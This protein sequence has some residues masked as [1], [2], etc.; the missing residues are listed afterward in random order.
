MS[1][2]LTME[3]QPRSSP[4]GAALL[5]R[6]ARRFVL[7]QLERLEHGR[8]EVI[9]GDQRRVFG[10]HDDSGLETTVMVHDA[11]F[12]SA[13]AFGG[14]IGAGE[15][16]VD[17]AW[18]SDDLTAVMRIMARNTQL[19]DDLDR[20]IAKI[21]TPL[22]KLLHRLR[23][24]TRA[25]SKRNIAAHYDIDDEFFKL[26]LD[27]T[28]TYSCAYFETPETDLRE[29]SIEKY[30]RI[31][32]KLQLQPGDELLEIGCG[33]GGFAIHAAA[34]YGCQVV[35]TTISE[36]QYQ[37]AY[38]RVREAGL[39]ELVD[40][41]KLDYRDLEASLGRRFDKIVSIEMIEAVGHRF[42]GD[43]FGVCSRMLR[44]HGRMA[45]QAITIADHRYDQYRR[46]VDFIQRYIFPGGLVPSIAAM[47]DAIARRTDL[48]MTHLED[49]GEHY[50]T[51]LE[52]WRERL[53][54]NA[55]R[56]R[57]LGYPDEFLRLWEFYFC[58]CE[59]GFRERT[60]GNAQIVLSKPRD[61]SRAPSTGGVQ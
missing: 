29:A 8:L 57:R 19:G 38:R 58:Y 27:E 39:Q 24:N 28:M 22:R 33:W 21:K 37:T 7:S 40:V 10:R 34:N 9:E 2:S 42:L 32:R 15:A 48:R 1:R 17:G 53:R 46:S 49:I 23:A 43:Y 20:G 35:A 60:I 51:T 16:Y 4:R 25:G 41:V 30:D 47:S 12:Y 18:S 56:V 14:S 45:L 6:L 36:N 54:D 26:F 11:S 55:S 50:A 31:C 52:K 59:G 44:P 5:D 3:S 13:V 61:V